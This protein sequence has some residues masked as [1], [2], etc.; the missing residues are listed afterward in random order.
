MVRIPPVT[1]REALPADKRHVYDEIAGTRGKVQGP[2]PVLLNSPELAG[3]VGHLGAYIRYDSVPPQVDRELA[4]LATAQEWRC[5]VEWA[6]HEPIARQV[7]VRNQ[8]I[9]VCVAFAPTHT[10]TPDEA[11]IIHFVR[12]LIR[13]KR[14]SPATFQAAHKKY[15]D[16]G[17]VDLTALIGYYGML[18]CVLNAFEIT[19]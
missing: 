7:G 15:G 4:I 9:Q 2:Y 3:R 18:A 13:D 5:K 12:E 11:L 6:L 1:T 14:V 16:K 17:V 10:L 8:A 19:A